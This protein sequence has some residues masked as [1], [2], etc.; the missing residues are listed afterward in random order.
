MVKSSFSRFSSAQFEPNLNPSHEERITFIDQI[1]MLIKTLRNLLADAEPGLLNTSYRQNG[2][3]V[4][5]IVHHMAD[6]DMNAYIRFKRALTEESPMGGSYREDLW[7]ELSD[8][9]ELPVENSL[10]LLEVL[11]NRFWVLLN[12]LQPEDFRRALRT[13]VLGEITLD[14]ALQRF[15]WHDLHH[16]SQIAL[17]VKK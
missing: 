10:L 8:Y 7:A 12:S 9:K 4:R 1:P 14:I 13:Q 16:M 6:N 15:V 3:T 2:W 11:H 17:V 5:Q